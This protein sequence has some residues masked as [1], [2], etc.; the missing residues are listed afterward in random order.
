MLDGV[1]ELVPQGPV[2]VL[3]MVLD[4]A[5]PHPDDVVVGAMRPPVFVRRV[6]D[7]HPLHP[8]PGGH[9]GVDET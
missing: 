8:R 1:A 4:P 2:A 6:L 7:L 3:L 5:L 9:V